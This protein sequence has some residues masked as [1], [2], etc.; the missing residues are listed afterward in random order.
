M[1]MCFRPWPF[2][3]AILVLLI[4]TSRN[5]YWGFAGP[6]NEH[7]TVKGRKGLIMRL[8]AVVFGIGLLFSSIFCIFE[9][10]VR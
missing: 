5:L 4:S 1:E 2:L 3:V 9:W 8:V 6:S 10:R 7:T